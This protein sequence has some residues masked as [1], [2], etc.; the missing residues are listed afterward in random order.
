MLILLY[1]I[2]A[3]AKMLLTYALRAYQI[4]LSP[5]FGGSAC[6]YYPSCSE[7]ALWVLRY[8]TLS[9]SLLL[10]VYRILRCHPFARGGFD[11]PLVRYSPIPLLVYKPVK[12][13]VLFWLIPFERKKFL[14]VSDDTQIFYVLKS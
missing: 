7:Y 5:L 14:F 2:S 4:W 11:Y 1:R 8:H 13:K 9:F 10:I 3:C 12:V 6:R